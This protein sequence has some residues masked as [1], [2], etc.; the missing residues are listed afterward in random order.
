MGNFL[1]L[2]RAALFQKR[3][4]HAVSWRGKKVRNGEAGKRSRYHAKAQRR[5]DTEVICEFTVKPVDQ[6]SHFHNI[7]NI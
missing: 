2:R 1:A 3:T 5:E 7:S 4:A 6:K